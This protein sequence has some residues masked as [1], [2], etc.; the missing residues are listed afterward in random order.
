MICVFALALLLSDTVLA[1]EQVRH[2]VSFPKDRQQT[3]LMRTEFPVSAPVTELIMPNWT[4]GSYRIREYAANVDRI[5]AVSDDGK[6]LP[7]RKSSKDRWL[8]NTEKVTTLIVDYEVFTPEI[9]VSSSWAGRAFVLVNGA[10]VF[11]YTPLT[12]DLPQQ[13]DIVTSAERGEIFTALPGS[14]GGA[15]YRAADYDELVDNPVVVA[16]APSYRFKSKKQA[17]VLVNVGENEFW[18]G[19]QAAADVAKIV[20]ETQAFWR[21]N[22]LRRPYWFLNFAVEGRGGLEHDYSTV[23]M[24]GRRQMG[25]R[26]DYIKWL[27]VVAHEFF[28]VWNVRHMR[29]AELAKYDYQQEQYTRQLWL[30]EGLTSYYDSLLLSRAGLINPE[31]YMEQLATDIQRLET[32]PGRKLR[33]VTEASVDTWVRHY[34]PNANSINSTISYYTK[35]AVIGFVLDAYLRK[36]SKGRHDLDD[37][38]REMYKLYAG[39]PYTGDDFR[40]VVADVGGPEAVRFLEPLLDTTID[41]DVD[42]ALDWF[43]LKLERDPNARQAEIDG[44][45]VKSGFG[46]IWDEDKPD[47]IVK[48]VLAGSS[49]AAAG[50]LPRDEVLAIGDER[51]TKD[52]L[53]SLMTAWQPGW[54]TTLLVARRGQIITLEIELEAA[55]PERFDIVPKSVFGKRQINRLQSWLG[56]DL[57]K[58]P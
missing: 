32:T 8:V 21:S 49:G 19:N 31:E 11:L 34:Q 2:T 41:P 30:A 51:L 12:R 14:P 16:N 47:L 52:K 28:H 44:D 24:T 7:V 4:P 9:K 57:R 29:P 37:V 27:G 39:T 25:D 18:D 56:Q 33:S 45:P 5:S 13:L 1:V 53:Q 15:G 38:M 46:V 55:I 54:K 35:G 10:S 6:R 58:E 48:S 20:K 26:D 17:Y 3:I 50:I 43:G 42:A 22:P 23:I 40:K 36:A